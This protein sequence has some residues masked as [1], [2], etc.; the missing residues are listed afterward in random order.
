[1]IEKQEKDAMGPEKQRWNREPSNQG[2]PG[3]Q[4]TPE[5]GGHVGHV[6]SPPSSA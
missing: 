6:F 2:T 4:S 5:A 3:L 1:M